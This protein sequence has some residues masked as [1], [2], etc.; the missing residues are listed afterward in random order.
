MRADLALA[1]DLI[2]D[3]KPA[4]RALHGVQRLTLELKVNNLADKDYD[5]VFGFNAPGINWMAG[6]RLHF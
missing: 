2:R 5:E 1:Y 6:L 4:V 3:R